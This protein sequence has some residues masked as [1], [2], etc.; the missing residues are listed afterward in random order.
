MPKDLPP[1]VHVEE[2][3]T[4]SKP[5][6]GVAIS[7]AGFVGLA[8][9]GIDNKAVLITS[10]MEFAQEFGRYTPDTPY[11][12]PAVWGFFKN[13]GSRC[14]VVK[15]SGSDCVGTDKKTGNSAGLQALNDIDEI[16]IV[17]I[18][19]I[20]SS[21]VQNELTAHCERLRY[22]F[23]ILDSIQGTTIDGIRAQRVALVSERG[24]GALY[25]PW[26][27][28]SIETAKNGRI[29]TIQKFVPPSGF[30]A[31]IYAR[32]DVQ[33]AP[34]NELVAG[35]LGVETDITQALQDALN[36]SGINCIRLFPSKGVRVWG[37][38]TISTDPEWKY[39]N[40][41]RLLLFIEKSIDRGTQ[42]V[43]FEPNDEKLWAKVRVSITAFLT[44]LW[45]EGVLMGAKTEEA[46]FVK[47][48]RTTMT[49]NDIDNGRLICLIGV[50][51]IK[52]SEF[53]IFRISQQTGGS[54]VP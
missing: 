39:V 28:V 14:F 5:I 46:F 23:A 24:Y 36:P 21:E 47:C 48:D 30:I 50:A 10:W 7:T 52:P 53:V 26:I 35:A 8:E 13:G 37:S 9:K 1:A 12:A 17:S 4:G 2:N 44:G 27:R 16:S 54:T 19:G 41:R 49:Q 33:R 22:R 20:T 25:Y 42:W 43:V 31:G 40:V 32:T 38:R 51:P 45:Q 15:T 3:D 6:E 34:A 29:N 11:L 18:P